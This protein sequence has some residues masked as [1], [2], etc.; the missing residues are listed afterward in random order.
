M[1][2]LLAELDGLGRDPAGGYTRLAWTAE[3]LALREWFADQAARRGMTLLEDGNGNQT[4]WWGSGPDA[5]LIG[6]HLDSVPGGGAF[7]GPLGVASAF[8]AVDEL[9]ARGHAPSRPVVIGN[10]CDEEGGRFQ[11]ACVGSKL[12]GGALDPDRAL[13]LRDTDGVTMAEAMAAQGRNPEAAGRAEWLDDVGAFVELHVEQGRYLVHHDAAVGVATAIWPHG[14]WR[15]DFCGEGNHAGTT[16]AGDRRDPMVAYAV[17]VLAANRAALAADQRATFGKLVV[18]PG[19]ANVIASRVRA[20]LDA[21]ADREDALDSLVAAILAEAREGA[22]GLGVDVEVTLESRAPAV[23]F[24]RDLRDRLAGVLGAPLLPT[25]AGHDA[26]VLAA[27][28]PTAMLFVRNP[29]GIS[30]APGEHAE[31]DDCDAG[32]HALAAV[33]EELTT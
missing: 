11:V 15:L 22:A 24:D 21:R 5:L 3:D 16:P 25:G 27:V 26:G 7:D 2:E 20:W 28:M 6:S 12:A 1:T 13:G 29:S 31:P 30:H 4:A 14:R 32:V 18:S 9:R 17:A 19:G 33:V 10:F 8:A 23:D